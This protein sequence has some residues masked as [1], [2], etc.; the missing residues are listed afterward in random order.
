MLKNFIILSVIGLSSLLLLLTDNSFY[1]AKSN[2][3]GVGLF[4][5]NNYK[6]GDKIMMVID[7]NKN[8][9]KLANKINH[10]N[11]ANTIIKKEYDGWYIYSVQ[12]IKNKSELTINYNDTPDFIVKPNIDWIC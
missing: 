10:C 4:V 3:H 5:N 7:N 2:I 9:T 11:N 6:K 12:D 8:I 1:I